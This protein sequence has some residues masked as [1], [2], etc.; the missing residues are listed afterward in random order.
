MSDSDRIVIPAETTVAIIAAIV[1]LIALNYLPVGGFYDD[2]LYTILAKSLATGQGYRFL[3]L[4]GTPAAV[5]YPPGYPLLL[6]VIWKLGPAFPA[7]VLWFKLLNVLLLSVIA[8]MTCRFAVRVLLLSPAVAML[9]ALLGTITIPMLVLATL[10]LSEPLFLAL[11]LPALLLAERMTRQPPPTRRGAAVL[12]AL[13]A[14]VMLVRSIGVLLVVAVLVVWLVRRHWRAAAWYLGAALLVASP[15]LLWSSVHAG[16]VAPVLR[17]SYGSYLG[18]FLGGV[19]TGGLPFVIA[20]ARVN[21]HTLLLGVATSFQY[22]SMPFVAAG[23]AL[24]LGLMLG[25]GVWRAR[26]RAPVTLLFLALYL[27]LVIVWPNQPLRFVWGI[28]PVLMAL[29]LVPLEVLQAR[30]EHPSALRIAVAVVALLLVP[31]LLRYNVRGYRGSWWESIPRSTTSQ[32]EPVIR[33]VRAHVQRDDV[34]AGAGEPMLYLYAERQAVP[35]AAFT[36][37]QY[38]RPRTPRENA[39]D[40]R[41]ILEATGA[42]YLVVQATDELDAA[43]TLAAD[44]AAGPRLVPVDSTQDLYVF[45][46]NAAPPGRANSPAR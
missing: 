42:R 5:H 45:G 6:A 44:T 26:G 39:D 36:A 3:N 19:H 43:R 24:A 41:R 37:V 2:G 11:L 30:A 35:S 28:W 10:V 32:A 17:G 40:L 27:G 18:W 31:G 14:A 33:W 16:D 15:W 46:V 4:P 38:L 25:Y 7:N 23:T 20:T 9:A 29:L 13:S 22:A 12:G 8:W 21:V 1:G 34:V